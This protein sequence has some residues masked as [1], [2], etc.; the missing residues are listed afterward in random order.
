VVT[1]AIDIIEVGLLIVFGFFLSYL[2]M[3]S[4][5]ALVG[6]RHGNPRPALLRRFAV[7][8]PAHDEQGTIERTLKSAF[9]MKYPRSLYDVIVV[10]DNCTDNTAEAARTLGAIVY[11]R[12]DDVL[13]GKGY[14]LRWCFD[15]LQAQ[16]SV[17]DAF[18]V[19]DA[20][21]EISVNFLVVM[22]RYLQAGAKAIQASDLVRPQP[23]AWSAEMTRV[24]FILYNYVRPLGRRLLGCSAGLRGNG[25]CFAAETLRS[26]PWQAYSINEDLEYG[27]V[28]LL[29]G[30]TVVFAPEAQV[31]ATM[32]ANPRNAES[33]RARWETGRFQLVR[34][35]AGLLLADALKR[36][37]YRAFDALVDLVTPPFVN[38]FGATVAMFVF[39]AL[40]GAIPGI[41]AGRFLWPWLLV[42]VLGLI[43]V[44]VGLYAASADR[45]AY[46]ALFYFPR[47]ALWKLLLYVKVLSGGRTN[48]WIRTKREGPIVEK[49]ET[50]TP[51]NHVTK[52]SAGRILELTHAGPGPKI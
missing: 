15:L 13:R 48:E 9:S 32:P 50:G 16:R 38:L 51:E 41:E 31:L 19:V 20:D 29:Q 7:I 10:A 26:V 4:L 45:S 43:H 18:V 30:F 35:Y 2:A 8:I 17:Y 44:F 21:S 1:V 6:R 5:L 24:G 42:L 40:L 46:A 28:L 23:G 47:Y 25:M 34:R 14:A 52:S 49:Q 36:R 12:K 27:L 37:S 33:Q 11:E 22:D 39:S 3:L